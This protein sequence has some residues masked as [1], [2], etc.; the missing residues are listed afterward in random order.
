MAKR[1]KTAPKT[2]DALSY[3]SALSFAA[4]LSNEGWFWSEI[5]T[6]LN[7]EGFSTKTGKG[8][9]RSDNTK[10]AILRGGGNV[11]YA[12][13]RGAKSAAERDAAAAAE[14]DKKANAAKRRLDQRTKALDAAKKLAARR[15]TRET[16]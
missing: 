7:D 16:K 10:T 2:I 13:E 11:K 9:W 8:S 5:R 6:A 15:P 12:T 3:E 14:R 1:Q 4:Y